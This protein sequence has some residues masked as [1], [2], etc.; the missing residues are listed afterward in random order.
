MR[1]GAITSC[2][3]ATLLMSISLVRPAEAHSI[4]LHGGQMSVASQLGAAHANANLCNH[5]IDEAGTARG[6]W[7]GHPL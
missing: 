3:S 2:L 1:Q 4:G 5:E 7:P 6:A